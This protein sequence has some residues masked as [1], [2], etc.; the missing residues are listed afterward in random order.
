MSDDAQPVVQAEVS[1]GVVTL[2]LDSP[3]NRNALSADLVGQLDAH[4]DAVEHDASVRAVVLAHT[5]GTFCAGADLAEAARE[6]GPALGTARLVALLRKLVAYPKPVVGRVEGHVRAGGVGLVGVCDVVVANGDA[7]FALTEARLGLAPAI[8][9][10]TV[11]ARVGDRA[12]A[13]LALTGD[14]IGAEEAA[15]IGLVTAATDD[16]A[17]AVAELA[18]SFATSSPQG[19]AET[20]ALLNRGLLAHFDADA[21]TMTAWSARLFASEEAQEGIAAFRERRPPR[22]VLSAD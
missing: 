8:I 22:W 14:V 17:G 20:K 6:G 7:T 1:G 3:A 16:G 9:S 18:S 10:L 4:L 5:G 15:R 2:T 11:L 13:R 19:L 12:A 21:E